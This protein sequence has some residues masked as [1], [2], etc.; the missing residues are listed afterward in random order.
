M[1]LIG[2]SEPSLAESSSRSA[3]L[4]S[5]HIARQPVAPA[6]QPLAA[7]FRVCIRPSATVSSSFHRRLGPLMAAPC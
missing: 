2:W 6:L 4:A 1:I 3:N 5:H 7:V